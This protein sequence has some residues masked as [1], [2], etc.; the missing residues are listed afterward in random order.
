MNYQKEEIEELKKINCTKKLASD[1]LLGYEN[2]NIKKI[3]TEEKTDPEVNS[4]LKQISEKVDSLTKSNEKKFTLPLITEDARKKLSEFGPFFSELENSKRNYIRVTSFDHINFL[5]QVEDS[6]HYF[7]FTDLYKCGKTIISL[8]MFIQNY[9]LSHQDNL[10][11]I[12]MV[13]S[14]LS[15]LNK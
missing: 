1:L 5:F 13:E 9:K 10:D 4:L 11:K 2:Q 8:K 14:F 3:K 12:L 7:T 6:M 15:E